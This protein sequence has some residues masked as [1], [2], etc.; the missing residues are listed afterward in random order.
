[1]LTLLLAESALERVPASLSGFQNVIVS[2]KRR[3]KKVTDMLLDS[4]YHYD[5]MKKLDD[6]EKRG[7]PDMVHLFL[8]TALE[9]VANKA[10]LL[11]VFVHTYND[12]IIVVDPATRIMRNYDRFLGLIEQLFQQGF[13]PDATHPLLRFECNSDLLSFIKQLHA[14]YVVVLSSKGSTL[15]LPSFFS[16]LKKK[17]I[18]H[19]VCVIGGFPKGD[20]RIDFSSI[21][22]DVISIYNEMLPVWTVASELLVNYENCFIHE[23]K[24]R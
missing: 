4:N 18:E 2:A 20:F 12:E 21:A 19:I 13:V 15:T 11:R 5:G 17:N 23:Y 16:S 6:A 7:R 9:S 10:G 22:D 14:D 24:K 8:L 3:H 1:M